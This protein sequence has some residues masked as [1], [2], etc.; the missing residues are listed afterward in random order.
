M[1]FASSGATSGR[2]RLATPPACQIQL[3]IT[4]PLSSTMMVD[5]KYMAESV[6]E[7]IHNEASA[8]RSLG[9]GVFDLVHDEVPR[10]GESSWRLV[11]VSD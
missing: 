1:P 7:G 4:T 6:D 10:P 8:G 2:L 11:G 3:T 5:G 9:S